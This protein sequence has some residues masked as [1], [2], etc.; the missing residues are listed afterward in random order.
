MYIY[1]NFVIRI[2]EDLPQGRSSREPVELPITAGPE[3]PVANAWG[4]REAVYKKK[5][6][7]IDQRTA[8]HTSTRNSAPRWFPSYLLITVI[9]HF[10]FIFYLPRCTLPDFHSV[11][12][13]ASLPFLSCCHRTTA[14]IIV[15]NKYL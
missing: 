10:L 9:L 4:P 5:V 11:S 15:M 12:A 13:L 2:Y 6:S 7:G 1:D 8:T 14:T 3:D